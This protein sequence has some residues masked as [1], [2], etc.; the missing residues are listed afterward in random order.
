MPF[1]DR[2]RPAIA[3]IGVGR[4]NPYGHPTPAVVERLREAGAAVFRTDQEG[5]IDVVTDGREVRV[6]TW[7]GRRLKR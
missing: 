4:G 3:L 2:L 1:L 6:K 7:N 5:Q